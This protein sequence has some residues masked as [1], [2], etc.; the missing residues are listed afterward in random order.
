M[1]EWLD[2]EDKEQRAALIVAHFVGFDVL[3]RAV[4]VSAFAAENLDT[5]VS[6]W[7]DVLKTLVDG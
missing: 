7:T 2:G 1:A 4:G 6:V 5:T 3:R